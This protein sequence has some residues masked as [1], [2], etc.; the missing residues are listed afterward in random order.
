MARRSNDEVVELLMERAWNDAIDDRTRWLLEVAAKRIDR[1][2]RRCL[3]L[4]HRLE[5]AEA[6]KEGHCQNKPLPKGCL[7][8]QDLSSCTVPDAVSTKLL[9]A[10]DALRV[11]FARLFEQ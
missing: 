4:S 5:V 9:D 3:R 1:L 2:G 11:Q 7:S 10:W 6:I 8:S